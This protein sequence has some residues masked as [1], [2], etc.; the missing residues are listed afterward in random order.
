MVQQL[1]YLFLVA[2]QF[3]SQKRRTNY[4]NNEVR[5]EARLKS[6]S[7]FSRACPLPLA[8]TALTSRT[9]PSA[10]LPESLLLPCWCLH[11]RS[12]LLPLCC[13]PKDVPVCSR[14]I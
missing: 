11:G 9:N 6:I 7:L 8:K 10:R 14:R 1:I 13:P 2:C 4:F 3:K 12:V 5:I